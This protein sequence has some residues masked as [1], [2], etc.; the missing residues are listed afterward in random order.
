M[1]AVTGPGRVVLYKIVAGNIG[2]TFLV[3]EGPTDLRSDPIQCISADP[4]FL[5]DPKPAFAIS[6]HCFQQ[7]K[8]I[9]ICYLDSHEIVALR[10]SSWKELWRQKLVNR[11][12][13]LAYFE[14][15]SYLL[16]WN[17]LDAIEVYQLTDNPTCH[18]LLIKM[19]RVRIRRNHICDVQ[20][21]CTGKSAISGSDNGEVHLW[22]IDRGQLKQVLPHRKG[23]QCW[24]NLCLHLQNGKHF[25]A[26]ASS[27]PGDSF[28][29]IKVWSTQMV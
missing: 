22:D 14:P 13:S 20:F 12:G 7:G 21:D 5:H 18:L 1:I 28:P 4:P 16:V 11:I 9:L 25:I 10:V 6:V 3:L 8:G 24:H 29:T 17:L 15:L 26:S 2:T 27:E 19:L 23:K